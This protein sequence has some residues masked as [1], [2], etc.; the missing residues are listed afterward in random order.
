MKTY[1][2]TLNK[3]FEIISKEYTVWEFFDAISK[4]SNL[5]FCK[6]LLKS[7]NISFSSFFFSNYH[8][9]QIMNFH[10]TFGNLL[11]FWRHF[12]LDFRP[13]NNQFLTKSWKRF[14]LYLRCTLFEKFLMPTSRP[15]ILEILNFSRFFQSFNEDRK[16]RIMF[17]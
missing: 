1:P 4:V 11:W 10:S 13:L 17:K 2:R 16:L 14:K 9:A 5:G 15:R 6:G 8:E 7:S 3:M 12:L